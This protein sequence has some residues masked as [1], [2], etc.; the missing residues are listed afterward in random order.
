MKRSTPFQLVGRI[1][2]KQ[3]ELQQLYRELSGA[4]CSEALLAGTLQVLKFRLA[5]TTVAFRVQE[6]DEVV[7]MA[8]LTPLPGAPEWV[9][10]L[11]Q[12]GSEQ[13]A[14][15]DLAVLDGHPRSAPAPSQFLVVVHTEGRRFALLVDEL[16]GFDTLDGAALEPPPAEV[17]FAPHVLAV[18]DCAPEPL[19]LLAARPLDPDD[20]IV[21]RSP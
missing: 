16:L 10:G 21:E 12:L 1:V 5:G 2:E 17:P 6:L 13:L 9:C 8:A 14:V 11:L 20:L 18:V 19:L 4:R 7:A 3:R 15:L